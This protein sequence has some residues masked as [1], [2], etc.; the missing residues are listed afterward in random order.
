MKSTVEQYTSQTDLNLNYNL[1][2]YLQSSFGL[3]SNCNLTTLTCQ[4]LFSNL[5]PNTIYQIRLEVEKFT[6]NG[7][8]I[9]VL[10]TCQTDIDAPSDLS[11]TFNMNLSINPNFISF[12]QPLISND[13]GQVN[14]YWPFVFDNGKTGLN[15]SSEL[16]NDFFLSEI[17]ENILLNCS[18]PQVQCP[19]KL[20][21]TSY[22]SNKTIIIGT[23]VTSSPHVDFFPYNLIPSTEYGLFVL[24]KIIVDPTGKRRS[25][26]DDSVASFIDANRNLYFVGGLNLF[27]ASSPSTAQSQLEIWMIAIICVASVLIVLIILVAGKDFDL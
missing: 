4:A 7:T 26:R 13:R 2:G 19:V 21:S 1:N 12:A 9:N 3:T 5:K 25:V 14:A 8:S 27:K 16:N 6:V 23:N 22:A 18:N 11:N 15:H 10:P 17:V 20:T 24:Y